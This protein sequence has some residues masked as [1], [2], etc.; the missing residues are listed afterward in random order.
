LTTTDATARLYIKKEM[1]RMT[2]VTLKDANEPL[3][4]EILTLNATVWIWNS[5]NKTGYV[6]SGL[7]GIYSSSTVLKKLYEASDEELKE[8]FTRA[9]LTL[10]NCTSQNIDQAVFDLPKDVEFKQITY[11][12]K[13]QILSR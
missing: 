1:F 9:G 3:K 13:N 11:A 8:G 7:T 2:Q 4:D 6:M 5:V 10:T 12:I